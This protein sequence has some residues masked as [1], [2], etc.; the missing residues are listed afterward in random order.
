MTTIS[1]TTSVSFSSEQFFT[2]VNDVDS[3]PKFLP[4]CNSS[5]V[6]ESTEDSMLASIGVKKSAFTQEFTTKNSIVKNERIEMNLLKGP[7]KHFQG[8]WTFTSL[9]QGCKVDFSLSFDFDTIFLKLALEP[10][11][12]GI[13]NTMLNAFCKRVEFIYGEHTASLCAESSANGG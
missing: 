6:I 9:E 13:A 1:N 7:F 5:K 11:F 8:L 12:K 2:V 4:W 10:I 3:Y